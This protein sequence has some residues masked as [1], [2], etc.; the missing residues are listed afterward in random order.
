MKN[1]KLTIEELRILKQL[2][3]TKYSKTN[4]N[5]YYELYHK[6]TDLEVALLNTQASKNAN[7]LY[8]KLTKNNPLFNKGK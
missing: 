7:K 5:S 2:T 3:Y 4:I 8:A 6:L 1:K